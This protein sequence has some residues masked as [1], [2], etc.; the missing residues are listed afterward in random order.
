MGDVRG[1]YRHLV[2]RL[3]AAGLRVGVAD[4][5]GLGHYPHLEDPAAVA[6]LIVETTGGTH[7]H[8]HGD[9]A[10]HVA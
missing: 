6:R 7:G 2:P 9:G 10:R 8:P 4:L 3:V 1:E 5:R